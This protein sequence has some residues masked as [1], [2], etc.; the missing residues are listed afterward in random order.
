MV[1]APQGPYS[2][3]PYSQPPVMSYSSLGYPQAS[4]VLHIEADLKQPLLNH[5]GDGQNSPLRR[6][7]QVIAAR[8][9]GCCLRFVKVAVILTLIIAIAVLALWAMVEIYD[10]FEDDDRYWRRQQ[11]KIEK[12]I[13]RAID[14][15]D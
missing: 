1:V 8:E 15:F 11:Y 2:L 13:D 12:A 3:P 9:E 10:Y 5:T 4:T 6:Q 14:R 7:T